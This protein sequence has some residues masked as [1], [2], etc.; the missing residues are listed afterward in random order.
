MNFEE[1]IKAVLPLVGVGVG[2]L[3]SERASKKR[4]EILALESDK[5]KI[6]YTLGLLYAE[7]VRLDMW[8]KTVVRSKNLL[9][10]RE[11]NF[12][13]PKAPLIE[14]DYKYVATV[15]SVYPNIIVDLFNVSSGVDDLKNVIDR[16]NA[17]LKLH[18]DRLCR[19]NLSI[20]EADFTPFYLQYS[21][22][23]E[24]VLGVLREIDKI[25]NRLVRS[26]EDYFSKH[27]HILN[28][29][30]LNMLCMKKSENTVCEAGKLLS[31]LKTLSG[32]DNKNAA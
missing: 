32:V 27:Q 9:I 12:A 26:G 4:S 5:K 19:Q 15:Q 13:F 8:L 23:L 7:S 11:L 14:W 25:S 28:P 16:I 24:L 17:D 20:E 10:E 2:F 30:K 22:M 6:E 18:F 31:T 3:L 21:V 1:F 29:N